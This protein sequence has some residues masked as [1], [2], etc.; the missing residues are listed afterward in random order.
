MKKKLN[1]EERDFREIKNLKV[2]ITFPNRTYLEEFA[3][4]MSCQGEQDFLEWLNVRNPGKQT[5]DYSRCFPAWGWKKE[6]DPV[7]AIDIVELEED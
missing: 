7:K 4:W 1:E 2:S 3:S 6:K 5:V